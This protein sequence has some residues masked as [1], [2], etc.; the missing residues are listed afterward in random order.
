MFTGATAEEAFADKEDGQTTPRPSQRDLLDAEQRR[1]LAL[2]A[3]VELSPQQRAILTLQF[4]E[5]LGPAEIAR[6]L[7]LPASQVRSQ[8]HRAIQRIRQLLT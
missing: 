6:Q 2:R 5:G 7:E 8:L 3:M 1:Q 4:A